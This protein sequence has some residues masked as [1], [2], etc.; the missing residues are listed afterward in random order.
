MFRGVVCP[1]WC[2]WGRCVQRGVQEGVVLCPVGWCV[3]GGVCPSSWWDTPPGIQSMS[4]RYTSYSIAFFLLK[5]LI[6]LTTHLCIPFE[7]IMHAAEFQ[8]C[9]GQWFRLIRLHF[10]KCHNSNAIT[11]GISALSIDDDLTEV[12]GINVHICSRYLEAYVVIVEVIS[13]EWLSCDELIFASVLDFY[14]FQLLKVPC[15]VGNLHPES[16]FIF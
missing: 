10:G 4:G 3:Q 1:G 2:V 6:M 5:L 15:N 11:A 12:M 14:I 9:S 13:G 16:S 7:H 8:D